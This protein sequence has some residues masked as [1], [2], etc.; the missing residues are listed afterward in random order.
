[1]TYA[2]AWKIT[3]ESTHAQAVAEGWGEE[4]E[5]ADEFVRLADFDFSA[6]IIGAITDYDK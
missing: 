3:G 5:S 1:M 4:W 6:G 2:H